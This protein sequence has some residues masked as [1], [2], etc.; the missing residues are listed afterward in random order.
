MSICYTTDKTGLTDEERKGWEHN[1]TL[2]SE[3][4]LDKKINRTKQSP[5]QFTIFNQRR[6]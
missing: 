1:N 4:T 6:K 2:H 5:V 3:D